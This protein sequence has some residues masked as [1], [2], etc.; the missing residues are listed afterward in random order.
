MKKETEEFF[1]KFNLSSKMEQIKKVILK[2]RYFDSYVLSFKI[3][4]NTYREF[5]KNCVFDMGER[6]FLGKKELKKKK[7]AEFKKNINLILHIANQPQLFPN[8]LELINTFKGHI[9]YSVRDGK[10]IIFKIYFELSNNLDNNHKLIK[11][12]SNLYIKEIENFIFNRD[13]TILALEFTG[14][15]NSFSVY[16][17]SDNVN[18]KD[19]IGDNSAK[20]LFLK[21]NKEKKSYYFNMKKFSLNGRMVYSKI[22]KIYHDFPSRSIAKIRY[23]AKSFIGT[24]F[25]KMIDEN[26]KN[27]DFSALSF[28]FKNKVK[29]VYISPRWQ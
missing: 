28:N 5:K 8:I 21:L 14:K 3:S 25:I 19:F 4:S 17:Y 22:Y 16:E 11:K 15:F 7:W 6:F 13:K 10:S 26:F 20:N 23:E 1:K 9:I 2:S 18:W 12:I 24:N 29:D 27:Y